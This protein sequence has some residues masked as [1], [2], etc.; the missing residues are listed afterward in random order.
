MGVRIWRHCLF[1][2]HEFASQMSQT[3]KQI[4]VYYLSVVGGVIYCGG[5]GLGLFG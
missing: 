1:L 5:L 2:D 3:H 4:P